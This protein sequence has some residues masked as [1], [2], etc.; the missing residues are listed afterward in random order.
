MPRPPATPD[1]I[2]DPTAFAARFPL[3]G[4]PF[5]FGDS[6]AGSAFLQRL[7]TSKIRLKAP[8]SA[9]QYR[10]RQAGSGACLPGARRHLSALGA[11]RPGVCTCAFTPLRAPP[12]F[13]AGPA[14]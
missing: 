1:R 3:G 5:C 13:A 4:G 12:L 10:R 8:W 7:V 6:L 2:S 9:E 11:G 14:P